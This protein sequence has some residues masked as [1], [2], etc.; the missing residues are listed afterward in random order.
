MKTMLDRLPSVVGY[1]LLILL[2]LSQA[3]GAFTPPT[4]GIPCEN[5]SC[6]LRGGS[7]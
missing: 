1:G 5:G 6:T 4:D 2:A 3:A 7:W